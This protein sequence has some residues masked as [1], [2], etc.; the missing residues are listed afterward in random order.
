[1]KSKKISQAVILAGGLGSRLKE[2]TKK[3][4]KPLIKIN[5]F[6]FLDYLI[7]NISRYGFDKILILT[8]Y[9]H[10][11]FLKRYHNKTLYFNSRVTCFKEKKPLGTGGAL[12]HAKK[13]TSIKI[14]FMQR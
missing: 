1:M 13:K 14:S 2:I 6:A 5:N 8:G 4:P 11:L 3:T 9:K 7:F 12:L 10:N